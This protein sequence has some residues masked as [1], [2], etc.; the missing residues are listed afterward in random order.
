MPGHVHRKP[1]VRP[2][3]ARFSLFCR[4]GL[5]CRA[6]QETRN[7]FF[8]YL[9]STLFFYIQLYAIICITRYDLYSLQ[10]TPCVCVVKSF[11][12]LCLKNWPQGI[13]S[14]IKRPTFVNSVFQQD[15]SKPSYWRTKSNDKKQIAN[16]NVTG[17]TLVKI[18]L[19][20]HVFLVF[21]VRVF[22]LPVV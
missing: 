13:Y 7:D 10:V 14:N 11:V 5:P 16:E 6:V 2:D 22:V 19:T 1:I 20:C 3:S 17:E 12:F 9:F 21:L 4:V 8:R 18:A 15:V